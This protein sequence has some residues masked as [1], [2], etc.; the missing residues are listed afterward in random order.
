MTAKPITEDYVPLFPW[1]G[2]VL[3]GIAAGHALA[4]RDFAWLAPLGR[5]PA[6]VRW[7]G[8]HSLAVYMVHQPLLLA[9]LWIAA[10]G[11]RR[12]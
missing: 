3:V 11:A 4:A 7:L 5:L 2:M 12:V 9:L 8:R 1:A 10:A 6:F